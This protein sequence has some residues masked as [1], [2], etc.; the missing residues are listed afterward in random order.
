MKWK[1]SWVLSL[2]VIAFS[3]GAWLFVSGESAARA[4]FERAEREWRQGNFQSGIEQFQAVRSR[5]P[6]SSYAEAALYE[7]ARISYFN[8]YNISA[9]LHYF[10][11]LILTYPDSSWRGESHL[12][13]AEI[14]DRELNELPK[15]ME[16]WELALACPLDP[17]ERRLVQF[18][19]ADALFKSNRFDEAFGRFQLIIREAADPVLVQQ[20]RV[21]KGTIHQLRKDYPASIEIFQQV[22]Q[23][24][25]CPDCKLQAQ[26]GLIESYEFQDRLSDAIRVA[27][28][29]SVDDYPVEKQQELL[30]R[31]H[32]KRQYYEP[33]AWK[34]R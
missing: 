3:I 16:H 11:Q 5:Y 17:P 20:S 8:L 26:L 13:L 23:D 14:F 28:D 15:A 7:M 2:P 25:A 9:S 31:L 21:R 24:D 33:K 22:L 27:E 18:K 6:T 1:S 29:I 30:R 34:K 12:R 32:E 19:I 10:E 4:L